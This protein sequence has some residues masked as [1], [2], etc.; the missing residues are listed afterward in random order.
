MAF[1]IC[2]TADLALSWIEL[3]FLSVTESIIAKQL[4]PVYLNTEFNNNW[5]VLTERIH[6]A[7]MTQL[8]VGG[9]PSTQIKI[10]GFVKSRNLHLLPQHIVV[11]NVLHIYRIV[12]AQISSDFLRVYQDWRPQLLSSRLGPDPS[13][14]ACGINL[15]RHSRWL[16]PPQAPVDVDDLIRIFEHL[17]DIL[18]PSS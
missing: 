9:S 3:I 14:A 6:E 16:M 1:R 12:F 7:A 18:S 2:L 4:S 5:R 17:G 15:Q 13:R 10:D 8:A 11:V